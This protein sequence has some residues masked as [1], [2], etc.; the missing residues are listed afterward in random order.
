MTNGLGLNQNFPQPEAAF[1]DA[2]GRLTYAAISLLR[3]LWDRTG[4]APGV[5]SDDLALLSALQGVGPDVDQAARDEASGAFL[6][7]LQGSAV[8]I[9]PTARGDAEAAFLTALAAMSGPVPDDTD[10]KM[11]ALSLLGPIYSA[12]LAAGLS[13]TGVAA[14]T[15]GDATNVGQF[16]VD[17]YGRI[18]AAVD[19]PITGAGGTSYVPLSMG[20]EP[21]TFVSD[22]A[23]QPILVPFTP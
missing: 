17:Q 23:G 3:T 12:I 19:V 4:Y 16:T 18:T 15:Y 13:P 20:T 10:A 21:L 9:D 1:V 22:G 14:G 8:S 2:Q 5:S 7:A 11:F 6:T